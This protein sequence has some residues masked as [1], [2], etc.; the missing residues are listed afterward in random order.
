MKKLS[1]VFSFVLLFA[2]I[3]TIAGCSSTV[4]ASEAYVTIDINPS[5]EL[6]VSP[7][8]KVLY[9]NPLNE[10]GEVLLAN[11]DLIGLNLDDAIDLIIAESINLG[12]IDVD[13]DETVVSV[14][15]ICE[16][17]ELGETIRD[18]VK[19]NI[20]Q[21]FMNRAMMGRAQDKGFTDEFILEAEGYGVTPGFLALAKSVTVVDDT[22]LLEDAL[23]MTQQ[24]LVEILKDAKQANKE[25]AQAL[26][27]EFI[28]ARQLLFDEYLPQIQDLEAQ[29]LAAEGDTTELEAQLEALRTEFRTA[30][31]ALRDDY[32]TQ[33]E[34]L[35]QQ[36]QTQNQ[37]RIQEHSE[38]VEAFM[39]QMQTRRE[40][41]QSMI[42]QFQGQSQGNRP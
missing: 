7:R 17:A 28:A 21:A 16:N 37:L 42:E 2:V 18:R 30:V 24:E 3:V 34:G 20:N 12:F 39:N 15:S 27:D 4:S 6:V 5:I 13:S 22:I 36:I 1:Y 40:Q 9:A 38:A 29:I 35:R 19:E 31:Q 33:T 10:D 8:E 11:L 14:S 26:R 32:H 23:V 41:M 25:V